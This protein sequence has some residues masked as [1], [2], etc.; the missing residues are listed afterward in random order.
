MRIVI[1]SEG[2]QAP[3][4]CPVSRTKREL[5][6]PVQELSTLLPSLIPRQGRIKTRQLGCSDIDEIAKLLVRGF[7]RST[8]QDWLGIFRRLAEHQTPD[9]FPTY[10]Y[11]ME[12]EQVP[13]GVILLISSTTYSGEVRSIRCNLS[14]WYVSPIFRGYGPLFISRILK[15]ADVTYVNVSPAPH[16]LPILHVQGFSRYSNGQFFAA[17]V[18]FTPYAKPARV[19]SVGDSAGKHCGTHEHELLL[20]HARY[21]CISLWCM[22]DNRAYPFV[23]R[24]RVVNGFVPCAQLIYCRHIEEF[25]RVSR[26]IGRYLA[27]RGMPIVMMDSN[28]RVP[29]LAGIY[30]DGMLPKYYKGPYPPRLGDLAYTETALFG[31]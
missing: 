7:P 3:R 4:C 14:S 29:G 22:A 20:R 13:V 8:N 11:V 23:F 17:P 24:R 27:R 30:I 18:S 25:V 5:S 16:T 31:I 15:N 28:G 12:S 2:L 26:P 9:G 19:V 6:M 10:G 21:G 1:N